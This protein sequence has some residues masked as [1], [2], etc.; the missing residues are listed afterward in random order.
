MRDWFFH[1]EHP[2]AEKGR[3]TTEEVRLREPK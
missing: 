3:E 2:I 1:I